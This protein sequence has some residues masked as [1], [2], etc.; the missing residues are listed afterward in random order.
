MSYR[1]A[2]YGLDQHGI[3]SGPAEIR[4]DSCG[5]RVTLESLTRR[6]YPPPWLLTQRPIPGWGFAAPTEHTRLDAC[7]TCV[8]DVLARQKARVG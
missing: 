3:R 4:C 2:V 1:A 6:V 7:P 5:K 8:T